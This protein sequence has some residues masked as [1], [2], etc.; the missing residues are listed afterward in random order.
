[1]ALCHETKPISSWRLES[2]EDLRSL[3]CVCWGQFGAWSCYRNLVTAPVKCVCCGTENTIWTESF[4]WEKVTVL[5]GCCSSSLL[6][7][8]TEMGS[9]KEGSKGRISVWGGTLLKVF[10]NSC[11]LFSDWRQNS[12]RIVKRVRGLDRKRKA[13]QNIQATSRGKLCRGALWQLREQERSEQQGLGWD[14]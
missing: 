1:M 7:E 10:L 9:E 3:Y 12:W 4:T 13:V 5:L 11:F 2:T 8:S 14:F 6:R